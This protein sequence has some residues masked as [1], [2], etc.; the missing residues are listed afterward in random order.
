MTAYLVPLI[1]LSILALLE[2]YK[3]LTYILNNKFFYSSIALFFII[4][5]GLRYEIGCDWESYLEMFD[6]FSSIS[7]LDLLRFN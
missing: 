7:S 6:K 1:F 4:F 5:I 3:R 2:N